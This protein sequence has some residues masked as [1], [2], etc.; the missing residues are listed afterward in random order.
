VIE[1]SGGIT[2]EEYRRVVAGETVAI[3]PTALARVEAARD[4][5]L[6][7]VAT[8]VPAYGVTTGLGHLASVG[9][10]GDDQAELQRSLLTARA[11]GL[12]PPLPRD[13]V[14]GAML[15]RL[16]G[17]LHGVAG[18][19]PALCETIAQRL[20]DGWAPVV[21]GGPYGASGE[22]G[23]LA[24]LFQTLIGE[25]FVESAGEI[26]PAGEALRRA[27]EAPYA[28][29]AKEGVGLLNGSPFATA[30][31]IRISDRC[32][33]LVAT[34]T[35]AAALSFALVGAGARAAS[36]RLGALEQDPF[37]ARVQAQLTALLGREDVWGDRVQPPVSARVVPQVHGTALRALAGLDAILDARL[38]G[39][40]DSPVYLPA[41]DED[42]AGL[43]PS[44]AFHALGVVVALETLATACCHVLNLLEKRLHRLLEPRY[45]GLPD[46][47]TPRP[48]VQAGVVALHK[49]VVALAA[50]ARTLAVPASI[51]ALDTSTGQEDV[52][53]YT[54]LVAARVERLL[55]ALEEALACELVA[56]R[57]AAHLAPDARLQDEPL[58]D[59]V[60]LLASAVEPIDPDRTLSADVQAARA[61]LSDG[62]LA[63]IG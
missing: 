57:Q 43:Y 51:H 48:G 34:A 50:E 45:S 27:G 56:L 24:H 20:D 55:D 4:A 29:Q 9:V 10:S 11:A 17:F 15:L 52:Q 25:G 3:S 58:R 49:T 19:S 42:G 26:V 62:G 61:L 5:M 1:L 35:T 18:V 59:A 47:L 40:T 2:R 13:V 53:C 60:A 36:P 7:H 38:A 63:A 30:L 22:I 16:T 44:G 37:A 6:D 41:G 14:R 28:P 32:A 12:E 33:P 8:G 23:P 39:T 21:P 31:G 46:Q 54:F